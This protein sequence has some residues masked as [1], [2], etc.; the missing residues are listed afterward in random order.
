MKKSKVTN[1]NTAKK[2][3]SSVYRRRKIRRGDKKIETMTIGDLKSESEK[4]LANFSFHV[5]KI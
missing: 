4:D 2:I 1:K 5:K 3:T